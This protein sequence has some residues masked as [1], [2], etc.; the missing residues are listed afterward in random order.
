VKTKKKKEIINPSCFSFFSFVAKQNYSAHHRQQMNTYT[1]PLNLL[2]QKEEE[3]GA[4]NHGEFVDKKL[5][6]ITI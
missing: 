5:H 6:T 3:K 1:N 4:Y 2:S